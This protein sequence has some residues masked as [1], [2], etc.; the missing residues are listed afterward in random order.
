MTRKTRSMIIVVALVVMA[1]LAVCLPATALAAKPA[2]LSGTLVFDSTTTY[3]SGVVITPGAVLSANDG[4]SLTMTVNGVEKGQVLETTNGLNL[5]FLPGYYPGKVVF[6]VA[7]ENI[8]TYDPGGPPGHPTFDH[9]FRQALYVDAAGVDEGK[10]VLSA[11]VGGSYDDTM[12]KNVKITSLGECFDGVFV[13]GGSY[14]LKGLKINFTGNGRSDFSGYGA[15][16]VGA[17]E[18]TTLVVDG[19]KIVTDGVARSAIVANTGANVI[20]KNSSIQVKNGEIPADYVPTIE[21]D[22]MR[23]VPWMLS[24]SGN[25]RATNLLGTYTKASYINSTISAEGWGVLST[26]GCTEPKLTA[27]N[28]NIAITGSDGYGSYGIGNATERFLGCNFKVGTYATISRG[29]MLYYGDSDPTVVA[30][31][32]TELGLGLTAKELNS[33]HRKQTVVSSNRF[34]V[35]WHGGGTLDISGGTMFNTKETSFLDKG[36]A[37]HVMVDGSRG[38]KL[39]PKNGVIFQLMEDDDPGPVPGPFGM[40]NNGVYHEPTGTV[41]VNGSHDPYALTE[42]AWVPSPG[43]GGGSWEGDAV[44]DLS[45]MTLKGDFFNGMRGDQAPSFPPGAP[46]SAR[47]LGVDLDNVKLTGMITSSTAT[48]GPNHLTIVYP[49]F[50]SEGDIYGSPADAV[51]GDYRVLGEVSNTASETVNNGVFVTL[52]NNSK[53]TVTGDCYVTY[54]HISPSS[55]IAPLFGH[56]LTVYVNGVAQTILP[57]VEYTFENDPILVDLN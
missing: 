10:S 15:A 24:L 48:H 41:S 6:T 36:Q 56:T 45:N 11:L 16:I 9:P 28:S 44:L 26:D 19:A 21:T 38:A 46:A 23:E 34:G 54:L 14:L 4:H 7:A 47:N 29:S 30:Q 12:A 33:I 22:R 37:V 1:L 52:E 39:L 8:W 3:Q 42:P 13:G 49:R 35:M 57:G 50:F 5:V 53:W 31:L 25:C 18:D 32:N 40:L 17:G 20:V 55:R 2:T 51:P 43:P 27:I